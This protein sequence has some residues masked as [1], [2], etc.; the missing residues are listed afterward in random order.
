MWAPKVAKEVVKSLPLARRK[1][2]LKKDLD[3]PLNFWSWNWSKK[4]LCTFGLMFHQRIL[5]ICVLLLMAVLA[6]AQQNH[7]RHFSLEEGLPQSQVFDVLHDSRGFIWAGTRGGGLARFDGKNFKTYQTKQ[8][9]INNF[10]NCIYEDAKH[11]IWVGTQ[12]GISVFNGLNFKNYQISKSNEIRIYCFLELDKKML[13]GSSNGL[14]VFENEKFTRIN[15]SSKQDNEYITSLKIGD[16]SVYVGT[17]RGLYILNKRILKTE[18]ILT[19]AD[20]LP[21]DYVQ[22]LCLDSSGIW[23]GTYGRGIRYFD[24]QHIV[25]PQIPLPWDVISYDLMLVGRELWVATQINGIFVYHTTTKQLTQYGSK[26]G[27]SNNHV[28]CLEKDVWGNVWLGTSGGGLNQFT[29]KQFTHFTVKDGLADNYVYAVLEDFKGSLWIGTGKKGVTQMDSANYVVWGL[30]SGFANVK[31]KSLA[32]S[33]DSLFWFGSEGQGLA[34]FDGDTFKWLKVDN[35][36]CGNYIKDIVTLPDG[37]VFVA[38]LDGGIS[39]ISRINGKFEIKNYQYLTHL[40]TNRIFSLHADANGVVWFGTENKGLGKIEAGKATM[41][42]NEASIKYQ[43]IRAIRS[44]HRQLWIATT[45]G[46]YRYESVTKKIQKVADEHLK[47]TNLYLLEFDKKNN[48]YVGHERGLEKLRLNETGDVIDG[49]FF[50]AAEGFS[51]IETC[52][53]AAICDAQGNMWFGTI[54]GLTKYN[55][56]EIETNAIRPKVWL[57]NVD[58]FYETLVSG[59]FGF[60]PVSWNN[61]TSTPVFPYNQNHLSFSF[62]GIDLTNPTKLKYQW[63]LEGFDEDWVKSGIK[64]DAIYSN[65]PPGKYVLKYRTI[66]MQGIE[67]QEYSWPFEVKA[68]FWQTWWFRLLIWVIPILLIAVAIWNY[69][70]NIKRKAAEER[71]KILV[72]KEL[73]ELE[74]KA[75]RLQMN[76]HFLFNALNSI[77]SL[78]ALNQHEEARTYLQKFAKLMRLTLQNSR[79]DSIPLSDEILTLKNY[80]ELEQLT[81]KP[82]FS[83]SINVENGLNPDQVYLPPMMLQPFVENAIKHGIADLGNQGLVKLHFSMQGSKLICKISDNGIGRKAAEEKAKQKTKSHESAALQVISDRINILNKEHPG[84]KLEISDLEMGT[85]VC[86]EIATG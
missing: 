50:G 29:G 41:V 26:Q 3:T 71:E 49:E 1:K 79:V 13:V 73:I 52:Q 37:R 7:F 54:N 66:S 16:G 33:S 15:L 35:G 45:D 59:K 62:T 46:L 43:S 17:N 38:T 34:Y 77:Q 44:L 12:S 78:V 84:N 19:V 82:A 31:I 32:Q 8:G 64:S 57:D 74:Q 30:D 4:L 69:I 76:P 80:M 27:L 20:G 5:S 68:P 65:I 47:S 11:D 22:S 72:E 85:E 51:G 23:I 81:K 67:S 40:P 61:L 83:F 25:D 21:D 14:Y 24:G 2:S 36:L 86:L 58:L 63:K 48:L 28:R 42:I 9:L 70:K 53:N 10:V 60:N 18:R 6:N 39:E 55:T 75:L 56:I